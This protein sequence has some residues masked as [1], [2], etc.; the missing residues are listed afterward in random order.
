MPKRVD[1]SKVQ[2]TTVIASG[3]VIKGRMDARESVLV[4]GE[5]HGDITARRLVKVDVGG[6][7]VGNIR[8]DE[9]QVLGIVE[10]NLEVRQMLDL[11]GEGS[12]SGQY[13]TKMMWAPQG[14]QVPAGSVVH[15]KNFPMFY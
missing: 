7:V 11:G 10:G 3:E 1:Y 6:K 4:Q 12:I 14:Y 9:V 15:K 13:A 5:F 2:F 8:A